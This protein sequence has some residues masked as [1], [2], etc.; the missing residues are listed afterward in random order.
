MGEGTAEGEGG[1]GSWVRRESGGEGQV[2]SNGNDQQ[3]VIE[4]INEFA[5]VT[6]RKIWT[7][8]GVRLEISSP[9]LGTSIQLDALA[10]E[11]LTWQTMDTFS[12]FLEE[13]LG[14]RA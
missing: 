1:A 6:V 2:M 8:N 14:P 4:V 11:S 10:L 5:T 9:R 7:R 12:R 3:M 13:P